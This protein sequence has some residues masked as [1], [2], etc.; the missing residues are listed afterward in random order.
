MTPIEAMLALLSEFHLSD[1]LEQWDD[2]VREQVREDGFEGVTDEHP[3][4][5]RFREIRRV[6]RQYETDG[7]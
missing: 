7:V 4:V 3:T 6:L 1:C 2:V 5:Q